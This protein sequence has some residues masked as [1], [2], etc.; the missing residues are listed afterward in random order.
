MRRLA[1]AIAATLIALCAAP[2]LAGEFPARQ[3]AMVNEAVSAK[4]AR[5]IVESFLSGIDAP[6]TRVSNVTEE[7]DQF[8]VE[9]QNK[10]G[11]KIVDIRIARA[12]GGVALTNKAVSVDEA[13]SMVSTFLSGI[14]APGARIGTVT[15]Q[16]GH[17]DVEVLNKAGSRIVLVR[18]D[19]AT[20]T[21]SRN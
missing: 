7:T 19:G 5:E 16:D 1:N 2:A 9:V 17:Y 14:D 4:Q 18:V 11:V 20:G 12:Q 6:G 13:K 21:I 3:V 10:A 15:E 8:V